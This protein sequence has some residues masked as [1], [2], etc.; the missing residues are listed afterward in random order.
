[1]Y[2]TTE[3]RK[4]R[5]FWTVVFFVELRGYSKYVRVH[6]HASEANCVPFCKNR[7]SS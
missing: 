6:V 7:T 2:F 5:Y 1:M 3:S 4:Q